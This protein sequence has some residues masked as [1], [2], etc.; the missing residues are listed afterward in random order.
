MFAKN[1][2]YHT[3]KY[4]K[5]FKDL[6][7]SNFCAAQLKD[8][9]GKAIVQKTCEAFNQGI[10]KQGMYASVIKYWDYLRQMN[11]DFFTSKRTNSDIRQFL[12]AP[13]L[14]VA[15]QLQDYYFRAG[16]STLGTQLQDD[17]KSL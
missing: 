17:I 8:T 16:L 4:N 15:E 10:L 13:Q 3:S 14:Q 2:D 9:K 11:S 1:Q 12:N 7:F 6:I 5:L